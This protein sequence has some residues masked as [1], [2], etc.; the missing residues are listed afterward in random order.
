MV[1]L[2][3]AGI[4]AAVGIWVVVGLAVVGGRVVIPAVVGTPVVA[5]AVDSRAAADRTGV[6]TSS[7]Y[8]ARTVGALLGFAAKNHPNSGRTE[9]AHKAFTVN[10]SKW[11]FKP[12]SALLTGQRAPQSSA[13]PSPSFRRERI[14]LCA[15]S[16]LMSI[17]R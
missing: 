5:Q 17:H 10:E 11:R 14:A 4:P 6:R 16:T 13:P 15:A 2:A 1:G 8:R 12:G 7:K 3:V 9:R